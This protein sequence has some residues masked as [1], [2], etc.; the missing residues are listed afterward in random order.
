MVEGLFVVTMEM[1]TVLVEGWEEKGPGADTV[2]NQRGG[3]VITREH[4]TSN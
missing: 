4:S 1:G 3:W 2:I